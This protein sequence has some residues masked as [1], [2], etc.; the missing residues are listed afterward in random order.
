[1]TNV[2]WTRLTRDRRV[3]KKKI[4]IYYIGISQT[5]SSRKKRSPRACESDCCWRTWTKYRFYYYYFFFILFYFTTNKT[6]RTWDSPL[7]RTAI[8]RR[9]LITWFFTDV[10]RTV[11]GGGGIIHPTCAIVPYKIKIYRIVLFPYI[12]LLVK[13]NAKYS[14]ARQTGASLLVATLSRLR[15]RCSI[16]TFLSGKMF[17]FLYFLLLSF[18]FF[19]L[20]LSSSNESR[21][22]NIIYTSR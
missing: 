14:A 18:F 2:R 6:N 20:L 21:R 10:E 17:Y 16:L 19:F 12:D 9:A 13:R 22:F 5:R 1:M 3:R 8:H 15:R 4:N 11:G 7:S